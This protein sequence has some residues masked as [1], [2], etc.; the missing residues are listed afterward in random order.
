M[1]KTNPKSEQR[2]TAV[3]AVTTLITL[4]TLLAACGGGSSAAAGP[5]PTQDSVEFVPAAASD[6]VTAFAGWL[7][8]MSTESMDGKDAMNTST[9]TPTVQEDVEPAAAP[10]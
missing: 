4:T 9:F 1:N 3:L 8:Q 10:L 5:T 6:G 2:L 7:K